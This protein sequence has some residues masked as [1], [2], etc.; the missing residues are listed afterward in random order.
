[1][2]IYYSFFS[3]IGFEEARTTLFV[4]FICEYFAQDAIVSR[5]G[6]ANQKT[7]MDSESSNQSPYVRELKDEL[8]KI[9]PDEFVHAARLLSEETKRVESGDKYR[10]VSLIELHHDHPSSNSVK[11]RIP[12]KEYP[13]VNFSGKLLGPKGSTL[14]QLQ[15]E[16]GCKLSILGKGSM[17]DKNKEEELRKEGG[18]YAHLN[19]ELH[20][21]VECFSEPADGY[22]R[23][24]HAVNELKKFMNPHAD[25]NDLPGMMGGPEDRGY[26]NG[27]NSMGRGGPGPRGGLA[28]RGS[29]PSAPGRGGMAQGRG[30]AGGPP[31][32][33]GG[34]VPRGGPPTRG[35]P[36]S[37]GA[38]VSRGG[39]PMRGSPAPSRGAPPSR[40]S[41]MTRGS[42]APRGS[43]PAPRG[44]GL[45]QVSAPSRSQPAVQDYDDYSAE[46]SYSQPDPYSQSYHQDSYDD[47]YSRREPFVE[48][49]YAEP[50][51]APSSDTQYFDYGHGSHSQSYDDYESPRSQIRSAPSRQPPTSAYDRLKA[52]APAPSPRGGRGTYRAHP[53]ESS[54]PAGQ[55]RFSSY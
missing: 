27:D 11:I 51:P 40:G 31:S 2:L 4:L 37:R 55:S 5:Q 43:A 38:P 1:M 36:A 50:A 47:G 3:R 23:L 26:Y 54:R 46:P 42:P 9:D 21:L 16:T 29:M 32:G 25:P 8:N 53:Y 12:A 15:Q 18:K 30:G 10:T 33:R 20:V 34:P 7:I 44:R 14:K 49:T 6:I 35:A 19:E 48:E 41:P 52:P 13:K 45:P 22:A 28:P 17:R 39:P 24:A